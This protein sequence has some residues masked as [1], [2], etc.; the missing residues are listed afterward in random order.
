MNSLWRGLHLYQLLQSW[1]GLFDCRQWYLQ[2]QTATSYPS[3]ICSCKWCFVTYLSSVDSDCLLLV[4]CYHCV[5][6]VCWP[7]ELVWWVLFCDQRAKN[8][9]D[10]STDVGERMGNRVACAD[11]RELWAWEKM[12]VGRFVAAVLWKG[13][14]KE[15]LERDNRE[16]QGTTVY[17]VVWAAVAHGACACGQRS[18]L[19]VCATS[20][21][22]TWVLCVFLWLLLVSVFACCW[23]EQFRL[24][25]QHE[26]SE[27]G[28]AKA[29]IWYVRAD[30]E[31]FALSSNFAIPR[32]LTSETFWIPA[33]LIYF[34]L[35]RF[36][37][38]HSENILI[39]M[40]APAITIG[41]NVKNVS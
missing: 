7:E 11:G 39:R 2:L 18:L 29:K 37:E 9:W 35:S 21:P 22:G 19:A 8:T 41:F 28:Y 32:G 27:S 1:A 4:R 12:F 24:F 16:K 10:P 15:R 3:G 5:I 25:F 31:C 36:L 14:R 38:S 33:C 6:S 13:M 26:G 23:L 17:A 34:L 30:V 20:M 40:S